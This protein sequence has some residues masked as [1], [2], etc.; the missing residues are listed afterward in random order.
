MT[1][2]RTLRKAGAVALSLA[3]VFWVLLGVGYAAE[4]MWRRELVAAGDGDKSETTLK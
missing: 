3:M 2:S 1:K 4:R